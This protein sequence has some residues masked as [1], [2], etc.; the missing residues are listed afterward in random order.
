MFQR[1]APTSIPPPPGRRGGGPASAGTEGGARFLLHASDL[2]PGLQLEAWAAREG[3]SE[4]G[5]MELAC[6]AADATLDLAPM[7]GRPLALLARHADG[8]VSRRCG[9][10]FEA[11]AGDADGGL[12]R[13]RLRVRSWLALLE[14]GVHSRMW[15]ARALQEVLQ[16]VFEPY[17]AVARWHLAASASAGALRDVTVQYRQ[18]DLDFL[19]GLLAAEGLVLRIDPGSDTVHVLAQTDDTQECAE[20]AGAAAV[21]GWTLHA[22]EPARDAEVLVALARTTRLPPPGLVAAS[23]DAMAGRVLAASLAGAPGGPAPERLAARDAEF[24]DG[25]AARRRL[26]RLFQARRCG[27]RE[28]HGRGTVRSLA[29]GRWFGLRDDRSVP[30]LLPVRVLHA[31]VNEGAGDRAAPWQAR[32]PGL[33]LEAGWLDPALRAAAQSCGYANAFVAVER[34]RPWRPVADAARVPSPRSGVSGLLGA[35]VVGDDGCAAGSLAADA[36]GRVRVRLDFQAPE[37]ATP[38]RWTADATGRLRVVQPWAGAGVA[39]QWLPRVGQRVLVGLLDGDPER[40]VVLAGVHDGIGEGGVE[41]TPGGAA[42]V[43]RPPLPAGSDHQPA[44]QGNCIAGAHAPPWH[45][46]SPAAPAHGGQGNAAAMS[47]WRSRELGGEGWNQLVFDD[48]DGALRVQLATSLAATQLN[49]GALVHQAGNR[50]GTPRGAGFELRSDAAGAVRA[51]CG[52][53][54][55]ARAAPAAAAAADNAAGQALAQE[56]QRL[57]HTLAQAA[58]GHRTLPSGALEPA[59]G[60]GVARVCE[61]L[62]AGPGPAPA[63]VADAAGGVLHAAAASVVAATGTLSRVAGRDLAEF[64]AG[65]WQLGAQGRVSVLA[66]ALEHDAEPAPDT[67]AGLVVAAGGGFELRADA[68]NVAL[69]ARGA[70]SLGAAGDRADL[71]AGRRLVLAVEGGAGVVLERGGLRVECPGTI[72]VE[73]ASHRFMPRG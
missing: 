14:H 68:A 63:V 17:A 6:R 66:G 72:V 15:L 35:V 22:G 64:A 69:E 7:L 45:G 59:G 58:T 11:E 73:A 52:L 18:T 47:G 27:M 36:E 32:A 44:G 56:L 48:S 23:V 2:P 33:P 42:A 53:L 24:A 21:G 12:A 43:P 61:A 37:I 34:D 54:L 30:P 57:V 29:P 20:D 60:D 65:G 71:L 67:A 25:D 4:P 26:E 13:Y 41:P 9:L 16:D 38:G 46:A 1:S 3:L 49:L 19:L 28:W 10:V 70:V 51:A 40:M 8:R 39:A 5:E 50:R 55:L 31:G 62:R